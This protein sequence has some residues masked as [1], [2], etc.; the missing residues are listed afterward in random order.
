MLFLQGLAIGFAIAAPV[1]PIGILCIRRTLA[2]GRI[3]GFVTGLGAATADAIYAAIAG[4]GLTIVATFLVEQ[5][6]W[7]RFIG[8]T[9]LCYLGIRTIF[10]VPKQATFHSTKNRISNAYL[11]TFFLTITNPITILSFGAIFAGL[12]LGNQQ[13][14]MVSASRMILGVFI[15]SSAWWFLL[16]GLANL[17]RNKIDS[18]AMRWVNRVSGIIILGFGAVALISLTGSWT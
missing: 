9:F 6:I 16:S 1:G 5:Q 12:G 3:Q 8:G 11:T 13:G 2:Q 18:V 17:F 7:I 10:A 15:G 4:F 14:D